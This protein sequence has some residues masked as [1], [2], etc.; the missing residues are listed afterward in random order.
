MNAAVPAAI[1]RVHV[2]V[3]EWG[4]GH[5]QENGAAVSTPVP[6]IVLRLRAPSSCPDPFAESLDE[7]GA[8]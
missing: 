6:R 5:L 7:S 8:R 4:S 2:R 3:Y 1:E